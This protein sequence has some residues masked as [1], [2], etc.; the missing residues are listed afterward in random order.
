MISLKATPD[1]IVRKTTEYIRE[2]EQHISV[3]EKLKQSMRENLEESSV[4][5]KITNGRSSVD[6][7]VS[8][9]VAFF[10]IEED[11]RRSLVVDIFKVFG[12]YGVEILAA[13]V[14][15]DEHRQKLMVTVTVNVGGVVGGKQVIEMIRTEIL[16]V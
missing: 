16:F 10:G 1:E 7:T 13:N 12:K 9:G 15:V 3:L 4:L 14:A 2:L 5:S 8:G 11:L 6:V